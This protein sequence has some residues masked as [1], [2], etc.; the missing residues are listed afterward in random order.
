MELKTS[1]A[2]PLWMVQALSRRRIFKT[3]FSKY[4]A[5]CQDI[6]MNNRKGEWM[7]A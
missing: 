3:S 2:L 7:Y 1:G 4:G 6:V 5:A